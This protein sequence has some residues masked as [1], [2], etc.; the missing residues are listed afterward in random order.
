MH[1]ALLAEIGAFAAQAV[2][3]CR[4]D[5]VT[6]QGAIVDFKRIDIVVFGLLDE[7]EQS[8][9][10]RRLRD[11]AVLHLA[12]AGP[13][14]KHALDRPEAGIVRKTLQAAK[15]Y[16]V[17]RFRKKRE[18]MV[19]QLVEKG[20]RFRRDAHGNVVFPGGD[21]RRDQIG[22]RL[23]DARPRFDCQVDRISEGVVY[24]FG[25]LYLLVARLETVVHAPDDAR[26]RKSLAHLVFGCEPHAARGVADQVVGI[27]AG[28]M[29]VATHGL[30]TQRPQIKG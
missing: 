16:A 24:R 26:G 21:H 27:D 20:V 13:R 23:A 7:R 30:I 28:A 18:L 22:H 15:R 2:V 12:H 10:G 9:E 1:I 14:F 19:D 29:I 11:E 17:A 4:S 6:G 8:G 25:H 5:L 3:A